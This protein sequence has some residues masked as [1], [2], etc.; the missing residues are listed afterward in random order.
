MIDKSP[1]GLDDLL[2]HLLD[3]SNLGLDLTA[4]IQVD[5]TI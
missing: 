1:R 4:T 3:I 2:G 5:M